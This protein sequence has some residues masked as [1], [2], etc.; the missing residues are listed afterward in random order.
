LETS[1]LSLQE[2]PKRG[3]AKNIPWF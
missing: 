2:P 1:N 3:L